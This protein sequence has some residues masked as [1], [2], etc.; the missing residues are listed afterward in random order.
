MHTKVEDVGMAEW[1]I[2]VGTGVGGGSRKE[3]QTDWSFLLSFYIRGEETRRER[4]VLFFFFLSLFIYFYFYIGLY[5]FL[6]Q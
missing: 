2:G 4:Q 5:T 1:R 6:Q 3:R